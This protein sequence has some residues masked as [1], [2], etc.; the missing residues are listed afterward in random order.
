MATQAAA[1]SDRDSY[2]HWR[3]ETDQDGI[4]WLYLDRAGEKVNSLSS[5]VLTE[6]GEIVDS[7]E[8][9]PPSGVVLMSGKPGSFIVGADVREFDATADVEVL[10]EN[11]RKVH[12]LF[13]RI[14]ALRFP[15]VVAFEGFCLGGGLEL[16]LCFDWR[17]ALDSDKTKIGFPEVNLGIYP[18]YGGSGR[19]IQAIGGMKAME[20]M[21]TGRML[22]AKA[23]RGIGLV[24]QTVDIHGSLRWAARRA[25]QKKRKHKLTG[26]VNKLSTFGP[27]RKFL[28]G[29]MRKK[30]RSKARLEHYPAPYRL[31]DEF[32]AHGDSQKAMIR[33]EAENI[34]ELLVGETS[35]NLRRVFRL[36]E[37]L[38]C[39]GK[40]SDFKARRMHVI[41]AGVMGGDIAAW[42]ALRG[43]EVTLQDREMKYI[44][45]ALKRAAGLFKKKLKKPTAVS[46]AK[47]RL[48]ADVEGDGVKRA[49]V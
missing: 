16:A 27:A 28:A 35:T 4:V 21:L 39:H 2:R 45:P 48:R 6:L 9:T 26:V 40:K 12:G 34:P 10:K 42:C 32:E 36:M 37:T 18:G 31:I 23:A 46:A 38:E 13:D 1:N 14:E 44:E 15:K 11:V 24:D 43:L 17:I 8:Q 49:D 29:Q 22:K 3:L 30:T 20:I 47:L 7:L 5:E 41:G 33:A 25:V 19:S